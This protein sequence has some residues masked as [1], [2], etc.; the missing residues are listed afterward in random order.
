MKWRKFTWYAVLTLMLVSGVLFPSARALADDAEGG[1]ISAY[2]G[3]DTTTTI[4]NDKNTATASGNGTGGTV[5]YHG[6]TLWNGTTPGWSTTH[7]QDNENVVVTAASGYQIVWIKSWRGGQSWSD[8]DVNSPT[9]S[10]FEKK[11]KKGRAFKIA[12]LFEPVSINYNVSYTIAADNPAGTNCNTTKV[13]DRASPQSVAV[14][15]NPS[16]TITNSNS[17]CQVDSINFDN[18]GWSTAGLVGNVYTTP[19]ITKNVSFQIRYRGSSYSIAS[20]IDATGAAGCGSISPATQSYAAGT[21]QMFTIVKNFGCAIESVIVDGTTNV[22]SSVT[23]AS[24]TYTFSN[25]QANRTIKVKFV[26]TATSPGQTYCQVPAFMSG[27]SSLKPN[28]LILFD[29]S[30]SMGENP[31]SGKTYDC[32]ETGAKS[33]L[34]ACAN[35]YGYFEPGRMYKLKSGSSTD[36]QIDTA[37]TT[38][39]LSSKNGTGIGKGLSGNYLNYANM[40]KVDIIRKI[41][42]GGQ[43]E[44]ASGYSARGSATGGSNTRYLVAENGKRVEFGTSDPTGIVQTVFDKVRFG[45]MVFNDNNGD[46]GSDDGGR[47]VAP[48]GTDL[49]TLLSYI[50]SSNTDP[51]GW[52]PLAESIY[53][54]MRYFQGAT[55]AYNSGVDYG[56]TT[57]FPVASPFTRHAIQASCQ[58]H[59]VLVITDGEPTNDGNVPSNG[60]STNITDTNFSTWWTN[61]S[62]NAATL[63]LSSSNLMGRVSYFAHT[64]DMLSLATNPTDISRINNLNIY[65]VFTFDSAANG[66]TTLQQAAKFGS[67]I[68]SATTHNAKP[69]IAS[70]WSPDGGTTYNNFFMADDGSV[71]EDNISTALGNMISSTASGTAAAVAN[72][73]SGERGANMIQALFY[74]QW[75]SDPQIKWLG[76]VQALW[77]YLDPIINFSG[78]YEDSNADKKLDL[79]VDNLPPGDPFA[80]RS[81]WRAGKQLHITNSA[82]RKIYTLLDSGSSLTSSTNTFTTGNLTSSSPALKSLMNISAMTDDQAGVLLNYV[83]GDD[84]SLYRSRSVTFIDPSYPSGTATSTTTTTGVWKLGDIINSTPQVQSSVALNAYQNAYND[85]TYTEFISTAAYK[86]RNVVY[87]GSNDGLFHAFKLGTVTKQSDA[88][89]PFLIAQMTNSDTRS[90]SPNIGSEEWAFIPNNA[91]PYLQNQ[92]GTN[93]CH[94]NLVDGA[95][96]VVDASINKYTNCKMPDGTTSASSYWDCERKL[97]SWKTVVVSSMGLGGAS[98]D[99]ADTCNETYSPDTN[100]ANNTDCVKSPVT[101]VGLSSYFALD[102]T[103]PITPKFMWEFS[104]SKIATAADKGLGFTTPGPAIIRVNAANSG[105]KPDKKRNGRWFAVFASG[106]TGGIN[107]SDKSFSGHSDQN[108]KIYI[109]DL[110]GGSTFTKCTSAGATGCNYWV[111]DTGIPF[112]FANSLSGAAIDLDRW[113]SNNDGNYSDSVVYITYTKASLVT[114]ASNPSGDFPAS[115][116]AWNKGGI[117]RLVTNHNPDPATWF[118]S[119]LIGSQNDIG[120]ITTSVGRMQDRN[121]KKLWVYFGEGRYFFPGDEMSTQRR[122]FGVADPCYNQYLGSSSS[123]SQYTGDSYSNYALGTSATTCPEIALGDV[124]QQDTP[125]ATLTSGKKGWYVTMAA[126]S[127][128]IGA[129]RVVSDVAATFN[130]TIFYTTFIPNLTDVCQPGGSTSMWAVKYDTGGTPPADTLVGKAPVQTSSGGVKLIDLATSFTAPGSSGRKLNSSFSPLGMAPKGKFPPLLQPRAVK[131]ILNIQER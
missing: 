34:T 97:A 51:G 45:L 64:H 126:A 49:A 48:L 32:T 28:V 42:I 92:A 4:S 24:N 95:P 107:S 18:S 6:I 1:S 57:N 109:V 58:K 38:L 80:T 120:P 110:N 101:G 99:A 55:S 12:V 94:Q 40:R 85:T 81:L 47:I 108:L 52:T 67:F 91:L 27:Q 83:R 77:Y 44:S 89:K 122:F 36:Y 11:I 25:I 53:E 41:L 79:A 14:N 119:S 93:Y 69:D 128:N 30:G 2:F 86:S 10:T 90:P 9:S 114:N 17:A 78:I 104:D 43:V 33:T 20:S 100:A 8:E 103:D 13:V 117:V 26:T 125:S 23:A 50:E 66:I 31:Y 112:A 54:A 72:N 15:S 102:V 22:T 118:L 16:F 88:T 61:N 60:S 105:G 68:E 115:N 113:N 7:D 19:D 59:F 5:T 73:K 121:N 46:K 56:N 98:R 116:T 70:E 3:T 84:N 39:N 75:P 129:E 106:P 96:I 29:T 71:L 123:Y 76:E 124:Q 35:F 111:K 87:T 127:G 74:P 63:G 82:D 130:G 131:Q 21:N 65:T 62:A 37:A